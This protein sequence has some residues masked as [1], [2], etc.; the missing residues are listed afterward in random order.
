MKQ[1]NCNFI[2]IRMKDKSNININDSKI[3][4][5]F[6][7]SVGN[8]ITNLNYNKNKKESSN[9]NLEIIYN[10]KYVQKNIGKMIY[11]KN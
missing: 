6:K 2:N 4:G 1:M 5:L 11:K 10:K 9:Q 8:N 3:F 7:L